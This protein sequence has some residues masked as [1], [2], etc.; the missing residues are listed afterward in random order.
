MI[1][2]EFS[3]LTAGRARY[4]HRSNP[5]C[6]V[7]HAP[8]VSLVTGVP[9]LHNDG[10]FELTNNFLGKFVLGRVTPEYGK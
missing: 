4:A 2:T 10:I 1:S 8:V 9:V 6:W 5:G 3:N 7:Y